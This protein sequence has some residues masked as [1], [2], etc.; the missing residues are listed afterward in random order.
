VDDWKNI[1]N[2]QNR[3]R[4]K[5]FGGTF[6]FSYCHIIIGLDNG[7]LVLIVFGFRHFLAGIEPTVQH[8]DN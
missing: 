1:T 5:S 2:S 3:V 4:E 6:S 8:A 7:S